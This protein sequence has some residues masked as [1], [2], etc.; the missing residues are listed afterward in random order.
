MHGMEYAKYVEVN[1]ISLDI[2]STKQIVW[3]K[4]TLV[5]SKVIL[6]HNNR[7]S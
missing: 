1:K 7:A 2:F 3:D 5:T 4:K 6:K